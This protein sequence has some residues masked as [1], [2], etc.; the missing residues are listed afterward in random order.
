MLTLNWLDILAIA[1][2]VTLARVVVDLVRKSGGWRAVRDAARGCPSR[3]VAVHPG[4]RDL[5]CCRPPGHPEPHRDAYGA[6][7][8]DDTAAKAT[9]VA[10]WFR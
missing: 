1:V 9:R 7:W 4:V 5:V 2:A 10:G 3:V 8:T 6:E